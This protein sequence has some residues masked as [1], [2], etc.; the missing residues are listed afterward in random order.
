MHKRLPRLFLIYII[1]IYICFGFSSCLS[2][3]QIKLFQDIPDTTKLSSIKLPK[4]SPP[5]VHPDDIL[6]I[7]I[8]TIDGTGTASINTANSFLTSAPVGNAG[9]GSSS[10]ADGGFLVGKDGNIEMPTLGKIY[11]S[12]LTID[13][14]REVVKTRALVFFKDPVVLVKTKNLKLTILGEVQR[15][16]TYNITNDKMT[17]IDFLA[18]SGDFTGFARRDNIL[19][20]RQNDDNTFSSVRLNVKNTSFIK[21]PY[22]YLQNNDVLYIEPTAGKA[23]SQDLIFSR[24]ISYITIGLGLLTTL[25]VFVKR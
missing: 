8:I 20:L 16:G 15:P 1:C 6:S 18:Y 10:G 2:L 23:Y 17:I 9:G 14:V 24:N 4:F 13:Q 21:S 11:V 19:L 5:I 3:K 12:G 7:S 25:L 22:Y